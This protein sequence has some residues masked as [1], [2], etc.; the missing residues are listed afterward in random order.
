MSGPATSEKT[1]VFHVGAHKTGTSLVQKFLRDNASMLRRHRM[2]YV[3]RGRTD[4]LVGWGVPLRDTPDL[5]AQ[6]LHRRLRGPWTTTLLLSHEN[7]IGRPIARRGRH[8]YPQ[9][10]VRVAALAEVL[11]PY[12]AKIVLSVRPQDGFLESYYLQTVHQ[13][14]HQPFQQW[15]RRI[16]LDRLSWRPLVDDL[17]AR[18]GAENVEII[19][20]RLLAQGQDAYLREFFARVAPGLSFDFAYDP[21]H[22]PSISARGLDIAMDANPLLRSGAERKAMRVFLQRN[23]SNRTGPRPVLLDLAQRASLRERYDAEYEELI[24]TVEG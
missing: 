20:F 21:V 16:Q 14:G 18:F 3:R 15:M 17:H 11:R 19:D 4:E 12:R 10:G 22:N 23:F 2:R 24:G 6:E 1:V 7:T 9:A 8:L 13:G 5:L